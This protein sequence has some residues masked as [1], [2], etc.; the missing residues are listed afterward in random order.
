MKTTVLPAESTE[1]LDRAL[2]VLRGG[3]LV[4]FPTD[5]VYGLGAMAF[6][7]EAVGRI[8]SAKGRP[9][10]KAIPVLLG[11]TADLDVIAADVPEMAWRLANRFWPGPLTIVL[12][13]NPKLPDIVSPTSTVAARVPG[14]TAARRLLQAAG[15]MAVTSANMSGQPDASTAADVLAQLGGRVDLVLDGGRSPGGVPSTIVNCL[16]ARP[17]VLRAGPISTEELG[18]ALD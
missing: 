14:H 17:V 10:D 4:A 8:F 6:L 11:R 16:G 3:G 2:E 12:R 5:T 13:K 1:G 7:P 9:A 18:A 15:P